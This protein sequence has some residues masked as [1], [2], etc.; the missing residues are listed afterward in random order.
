[1]KH[2][3]FPLIFFS[4]LTFTFASSTELIYK[5]QDPLDLPFY[6]D[7]IFKISKNSSNTVEIERRIFGGQIAIRGQFPYTVGLHMITML[8]IFVCG[9]SLIK[10][11]WVLTAAHCIYDFNRITVM[12]GTTNRIRGPFSYTFEVTN[13]RHIISHPNYHAMTLENDVGL[14]FLSTAHETILNHQ[15]VSTIALPLRTDISINLV[16]MNSTVS[17]FG[18]TFNAPNNSPSD[19]MRFV[20]VP[21]MS[22]MQCRQSFGQFILDSNICVDTTGGRSP[23][24]GDS[25]GPLTVEIEQGRSVLIGVVSFGR[26]EGC[27][28]GYPAVFARTT[29]FLDWIEQVT[30]N[31][32]KMTLKFIYF[33]II[34]IIIFEII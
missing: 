33:F 10:F 1:M 9:G 29:S 24:S 3:L 6:R 23:C 34:F 15:F 8:N 12:L 16:G 17:G 14:I 7:V 11:N 2:K 13:T 25:G 20:S 28:L 18:A 19:V 5:Q 22:N 4:I 26:I 30:S 27:G 32:Y 21:I 31:G